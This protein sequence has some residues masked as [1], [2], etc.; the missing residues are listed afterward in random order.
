MGSRSLGPTQSDRTSKCVFFR[1]TLSRRN[2][3]RPN[4]GHKPTAGD[5][6]PRVWHKPTTLP[7][8]AHGWGRPT[9]RLAPQ[10]D[11]LPESR[12]QQV[13]EGFEATKG[14]EQHGVTP[15]VRR[16]ATQVELI[17]P[18][19]A[20]QVSRQ[21]RQHGGSHT[22]HSQQ[23]RGKWGA[24]ESDWLVNQEANQSGTGEHEAP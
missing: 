14:R 13:F 1:Q 3:H 22:Q 23:G 12:G 2:R 6:R 16:R 4:R 7:E 20:L 9:Q 24:A 11:S 10:V 15:G 18:P 19:T 21:A 5:D 17:G 8:S